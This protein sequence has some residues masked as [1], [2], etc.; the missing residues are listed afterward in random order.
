MQKTMDREAIYNCAH[1]RKYNLLQG[2]KKASGT[3]CQ[4]CVL[5]LLTETIILHSSLHPHPSF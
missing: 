3:I 5:K 2:N 4:D 1:K